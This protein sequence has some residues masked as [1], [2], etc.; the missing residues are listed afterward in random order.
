VG[1]GRQLLPDCNASSSLAP[2]PSRTGEHAATSGTPCADRIAPHQST[3]GPPHQSPEGHQWAPTRDQRSVDS[4]AQNITPERRL[5]S[6]RRPAR[7]APRRVIPTAPRSHVPG[8]LLRRRASPELHCSGVAAPHR[9]G[10]I[11]RMWRNSGIRCHLSVGSGS[12]TSRRRSMR[13][14]ASARAST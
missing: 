8:G 5:R 6:R 11:A 14:P 9:G 7:S 12:P 2:E 13:N 10:R 1:V 3:I 4:P